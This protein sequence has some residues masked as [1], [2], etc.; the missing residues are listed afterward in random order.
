[1][2]RKLMRKSERSLC[3]WP[4]ISF[5]FLAQFQCCSNCI[6]NCQNL[7]K[8][9]IQ[10]LALFVNDRRMNEMEENEQASKL[11]LR[12]SARNNPT[13]NA[14]QSCRLE[15]DYSLMRTNM[16]F[17]AAFNFTLCDEINVINICF[18]FI[19][20][21]F[22]LLLPYAFW[23]NGCAIYSIWNILN[24]IFDVFVVVVMGLIKWMT[25]LN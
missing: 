24:T 15:N 10:S 1:M 21:F 3:Y 4:S 23:V 22:W 5:A 17:Y 6:S 18:Q 7:H 2:I 14:M 19:H 8:K 20:M 12:I 16:R 11:P 9:I 25:D 13:M